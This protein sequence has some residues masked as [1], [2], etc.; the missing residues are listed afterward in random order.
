MADRAVQVVFRSGFLLDVLS[1]AVDGSSSILAVSTSSFLP[2][3][4]LMTSG[5]VATVDS[6][7]AVSSTSAFS[8]SDLLP[9]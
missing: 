1:G 2:Q 7:S 4:F 6:L 9:Q 5:D 8:T 3:Y